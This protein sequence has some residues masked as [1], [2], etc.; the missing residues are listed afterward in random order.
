MHLL[1]LGVS[2]RTA[3]VEIRER[4]DFGTRGLDE[5]LGTLIERSRASECAVVSTCNRA[6]L[7]VACD[8]VTAARQDLLVL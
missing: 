4:L 2:H 7:Y 5:A 6:E 8:D 1:L 3:P